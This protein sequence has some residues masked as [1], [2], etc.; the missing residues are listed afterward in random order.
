MG[1]NTSPMDLKKRL[2]LVCLIIGAQCLYT[3]T[4]RTM[5]GGWMPKT[6]LDNYIPI[7]PVW[8]VPYL[9]VIAVW[10][11]FS[12]LAAWKMDERLF[13]AY[14]VASLATILPSM[15]FFVLYP[16]YVERPVVTGTDWASGLLRLLYANDRANNALPSGHM[17]F[18]VLL[19]YFVTRWKPRLLWFAVLMVILV[20]CSTLFTGQHYVLDLV[21]GALFAAAG[22]S[23]GMWW[24]YRRPNQPPISILDKFSE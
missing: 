10:V 2:I 14:V 22:I 15:L 7:W 11:S 9:L 23:F 24:E 21:G 1:Y 19:A 6:S 20:I 12:L 3:F 5:Q 8:V 17:Y 16:T 13:R 4:N 18:A